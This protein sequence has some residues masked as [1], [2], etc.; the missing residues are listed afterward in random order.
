MA[1]ALEDI[2]LRDLIVGGHAAITVVQQNPL[3]AT[4]EEQLSDAV[5]SVYPPEHKFLGRVLNK[6]DGKPSVVYRVLQ[7]LLLFA[8]TWFVLYGYQGDVRQWQLRTVTHL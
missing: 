3:A 8:G 2:D 5:L 6:A 4:E 1:E 7:I